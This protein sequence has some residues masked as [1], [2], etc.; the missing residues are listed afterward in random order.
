MNIQAR[1]VEKILKDRVQ[2][3]KNEIAHASKVMHQKP[4]FVLSN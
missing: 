2:N 1:L 4:S 3:L